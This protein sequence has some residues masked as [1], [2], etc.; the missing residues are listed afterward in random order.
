[1][2]DHPPEDRTPSNHPDNLESW[3]ADDRIIHAVITLRPH[4]K[5]G[6]VGKAAR[7]EPRIDHAVETLTPRGF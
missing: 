7:C 1:L 3:R 6:P 5:S 4:P 2:L